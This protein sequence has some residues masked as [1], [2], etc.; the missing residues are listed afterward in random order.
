MGEFFGLGTSFLSTFH[1]LE[2]GHMAPT[3]LQGRLGN[4]VS[5][6][7]QEDKEMAMVGT[8]FSVIPLS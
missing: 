1:R 5:L 8:D 4:V 2:L 7:T 3:S 6:E